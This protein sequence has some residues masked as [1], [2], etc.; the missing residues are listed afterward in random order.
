M[1]RFGGGKRGN[2]SHHPRGGKEG[3]IDK[4]RGDRR[5]IAG[6]KTAKQNRSFQK[7]IFGKKR[8]SEN[9]KTRR[10]SET[11]RNLA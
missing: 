3:G 6:E 4:I 2:A 10:P 5:V 7:S 1:T 8:K 9:S 11:Q